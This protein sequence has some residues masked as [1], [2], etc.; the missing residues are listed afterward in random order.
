[1]TKQILGFYSHNYKIFDTIEEVKQFN[2][3]KQ[4]FKGLI[5]N[6][7]VDLIEKNPFILNQYWQTIGMINFLVVSAYRKKI[8]RASFYEV[9]QCL[10]N[11]INVYEIYKAGKSY[12]TRK[13]VGLK[14]VNE[15]NLSAYAVLVNNKMKAKAQIKSTPK[16]VKD[17]YVTKNLFNN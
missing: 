5:I 4:N 10:F 1:M 14:V 6:P 15:K 12:A 3:I 8:D 13:V 11:R 7:N 2:W 16:I 9:K 17:N